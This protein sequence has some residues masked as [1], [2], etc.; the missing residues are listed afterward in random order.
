MT[1]PIPPTPPPTPPPSPA[2]ADAAQGPAGPAGPNA[3]GGIQDAQFNSKMAGVENTQQVQPT[4][5][6]ELKDGI[7]PLDQVKGIRDEIASIRN[8]MEAK[9]KAGGD[10]EGGQVNLWRMLDLQTR[11]Q[12]VHFRVEM[13]TKLVEHATGGVKQLSQTQT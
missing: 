4:G 2:G 12:D 6:I 8:E 13:V 10:V 1:M 9:A 5:R 3:P 11:A 7:N